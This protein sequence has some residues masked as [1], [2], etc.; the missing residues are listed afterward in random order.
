MSFTYNKIV[1]RLMHGDLD[2]D[3]VDARFLLAM[4]NTTADTERSATTIAGFTTL[5]EFDG[6]NYSTG[7]IALTGETVTED[8]GSNRTFLDAND[9]APA[10]TALGAGTRQAQGGVLYAWQG[11]LG[12]SWPIAWIDSGGFPFTASGANVNITWNAAG[13]WQITCP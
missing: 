3:T 1:S 2:L 12:S 4:T 10:W 7:G 13:I 6:A 8:F 11:T 9:V 5:D